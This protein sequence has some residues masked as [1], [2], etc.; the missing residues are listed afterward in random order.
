MALD[1]HGT[2]INLF[3]NNRV[4]HVTFE[5]RY[6]KTHSRGHT[7][8]TVRDTQNPRANKTTTRLTRH[9]FIYSMI[10]QNGFPEGKLKARFEGD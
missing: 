5:I 8:C 2:N 1:W 7:S 9:R 3:F 6:I 4:W 10:H